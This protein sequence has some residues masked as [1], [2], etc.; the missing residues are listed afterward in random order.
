MN[1]VTLTRG[2]GLTL[3]SLLLLLNAC[4][5]RTGVYPFDEL[6][7]PEQRAFNGFALLKKE[8]LADAKR[9]FEQALQ[10]RPSHSAAHRGLGLV[11]GMKADFPRA[12][13]AMSRAEEYAEDPVNRALAEVGMMSLYRMEAKAGWL[14]KVEMGFGEALSWSGDLPEAYLELGLSYKN[15]YRFR[16]AEEAFQEIVKLDKTLLNEAREE[17]EVLDKIRRAEPRSALGK[18]VVLVKR[19]N[20]AESAGLLAKEFPID[21]IQKEAAPK[22]GVQLPI[23]PPDVRN[24]RMK[25]EILIVLERN[26]LGLGVLS[27]GSFGVDQYMTR[28]GFATVMADILVKGSGKDELK[29]HYVQAESPFQD[30]RNNSPH[31]ISIMICY[32][33]AGIMEGSKGYFHPMETISGVDALLILRKAESKI[34]RN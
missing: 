12:F 25:D 2:L 29:E 18:E 19:I 32:D 1:S 17:L 24:H 21:R 10:L 5:P 15:A 6:N 28:A 27:D 20:R 9:E 34:K 4:G 7:T 30:V 16:D 22:K 26:I 8:Q 13:A 11:Y 33:W 23:L 31:F 3:M 14:A